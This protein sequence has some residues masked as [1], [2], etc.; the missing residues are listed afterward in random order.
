MPTRRTNAS[1]R[2]VEYAIGHVFERK[3]VVPRAGI[4]RD[5][6]AAL[7]GPGDRRA[8]ADARRSRSDL[9]IG[10]RNGRRMATTRDVLE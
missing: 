9:I 5:G 1:A 10:E 7:G 6:S 3:S 2:A 4:A 8:G